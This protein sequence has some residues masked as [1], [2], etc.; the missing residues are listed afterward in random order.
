MSETT[1]GK[2]FDKIESHKIALLVKGNCIEQVKDL[3]KE[4]AK[5]GKL[6]ELEVVLFYCSKNE[7]K[8]Q[9]K[10]ELALLA[11]KNPKLQIVHVLTS[12]DEEQKEEWHGEEG[13]IDRKMI[14]RHLDNEQD[15]FFLIVGTPIFNESLQKRLEDELAIKPEMI[16]VENA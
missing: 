15:F 7:E 4:L 6:K 12:L 1:L 2:K 10:D 13:F 11:E 3:L 8:I 14:K 5:A 16:E 9:F